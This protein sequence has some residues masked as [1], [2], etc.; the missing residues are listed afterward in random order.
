M[1]FLGPMITS[2][3]NLEGTVP[4]LQE[5]DFYSRFFKIN[6]IQ[7]LLEY[8][9]AVIDQREALGIM[10]HNYRGLNM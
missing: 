8:N 6:D 7:Q 4:F 1:Y 5:A 9:A 3:L 2:Q 10:L